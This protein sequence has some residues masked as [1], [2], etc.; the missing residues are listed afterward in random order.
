MG[1]TCSELLRSLIVDLVKARGCQIR[2]QQHFDAVFVVLNGAGLRC[3]LRFNEWL[4]V[5]R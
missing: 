1:E 4:E 5:I 3:V 2:L